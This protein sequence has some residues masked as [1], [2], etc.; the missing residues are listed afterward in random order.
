MVSREQTAPRA[1]A[2]RKA[3]LEQRRM[4]AVFAQAMR[5]YDR[6][7]DRRELRMPRSA[8]RSR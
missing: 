2:I 6:S 5:E 8:A 3:R 4:H 7:G 1:A